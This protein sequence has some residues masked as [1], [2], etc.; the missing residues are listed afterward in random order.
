MVPGGGGEE[1]SSLSVDFVQ[2]EAEVF[3]RYCNTSK[4]KVRFALR[5]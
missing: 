2:M 5:R 1:G 4:E 3:S